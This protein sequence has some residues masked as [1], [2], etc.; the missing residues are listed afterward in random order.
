MIHANNYETGSTFVSY[1]VKTIGFFFSGHSVIY[2]NRLLVVY[3]NVSNGIIDNCYWT[4]CNYMYNKE[5]NRCL[6]Y[7]HHIQVLVRISTL[8]SHTV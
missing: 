5:T 4:K 8:I 7:V 1:S 6:R 2:N 3:P